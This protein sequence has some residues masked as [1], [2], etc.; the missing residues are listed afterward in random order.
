LRNQRL[1]IDS[2]VQFI[3]SAPWLSSCRENQN[4]PWSRTTGPKSNLD[5][6]QFGDVA[7]GKRGCWQVRSQIRNMKNRFRCYIHWN[8]CHRTILKTKNGYSQ[9]DR[10]FQSFAPWLSS[11][12]FRRPIIGR[13]LII[14]DDYAQ[15]QSNPA[16]TTL[17]RFE[18][19]IT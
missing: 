3:A 18:I 10:I 13:K 19:A 2:S 7:P 11:P 5:L 16:S 9:I 1:G 6:I 12:Y 15:M 8:K 4:S 17:T 14:Q